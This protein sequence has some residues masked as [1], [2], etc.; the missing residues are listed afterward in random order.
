MRGN[1]R[2]M[3]DVNVVRTDRGDQGHARRERALAELAGRQHGVLAYAQLRAAGVSR[4][5][6]YRRV[7]TGRLHRL[8]RGVYAVGHLAQS[9]DSRRVAAVFAC[10]PHALLSHVDAAALWA[11]RRSDAGKIHVTV[12]ASG[13]RSPAGVVLHCACALHPEDR[14]EIDGIP[15]TSLARTL[16]DLTELLPVGQSERAFEQAERL[17]I[18][19]LRA[20]ERLRE[21]SRGRHG[22]KPVTAI[23][24]RQSGPPPDTWSELE[25][26]F[27]ELCRKAGLPLPALNAVVEGYVVDAHWPSARLIVELDGYSFHAPDSSY[28]RDRVRDVELH[29]AGYTVL[30]F[31]YRRIAKEPQRVVGIVRRALADRSPRAQPSA[32]PYWRS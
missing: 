19:D 20:L 24:V 9:A 17:G 4:Q 7:E 1:L 5:A 23:L 27:F 26:R 16:F 29:L 8:H 15:V 14:A 25:R 32:R 30:R 22:L 18:F 28:E 31:T 6:I 21:R 10:G 11:L 2:L 3:P 12:C 13:R